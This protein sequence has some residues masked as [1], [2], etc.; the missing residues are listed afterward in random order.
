MYILRDLI[1]NRLNALR[2]QHF[3]HDV[4]SDQRLKLQNYIKMPDEWLRGQGHCHNL[5]TVNHITSTW[6]SECGGKQWPVYKPLKHQVW[7]YKDITTRTNTALFHDLTK[8]VRLIVFGFLVEV[9]YLF[10]FTWIKTQISDLVCFYSSK[11]HNYRNKRREKCEERLK[12]WMF[13]LQ[14]LNL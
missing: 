8:H 9:K 11:S 2:W 7:S 12:G 10:F 1:I 5:K 3:K 4:D 13:V 6:T 14:I